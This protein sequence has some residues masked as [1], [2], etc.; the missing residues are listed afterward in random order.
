MYTMREA[1]YGPEASIAKLWTYG[2]EFIESEQVFCCNEAPLANGQN[3]ADI[4]FYY[5]KEGYPEP[6]AARTE[7]TRGQIEDW[8][9]VVLDANS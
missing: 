3:V 4:L 1:P 6:R 9:Y 2:I 7:L 8:Y 5:Q